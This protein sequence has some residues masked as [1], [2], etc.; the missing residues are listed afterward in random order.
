MVEQSGSVLFSAG[1]CSILLQLLLW[2]EV[3]AVWKNQQLSHPAC[4]PLAPVGKGE[5]NLPTIAHPG[6]RLKSPQ[7][8]SPVQKVRI[9]CL[10]RHLS[11]VEGF[12]RSLGTGS[13]GP[14]DS[15]DTAHPSAAWSQEEPPSKQ[16]SLGR[17]TSPSPL[18]PSVGPSHWY[19]C[20]WLTQLP[21]VNRHSRGFAPA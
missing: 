15:S 2:L 16:S 5:S 13:Q 12:K 9:N 14:G 20:R 6:H 8:I 7:S 21:A 1:F 19:L 10:N 17:L 18:C 3:S 11:R 4:P